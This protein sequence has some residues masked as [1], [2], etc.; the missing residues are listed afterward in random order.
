[1]IPVT[2]G[3]TSRSKK[4]LHKRRH[5]TNNMRHCLSKCVVFSSICI[6]L[7]SPVIA[8]A[9]IPLP[10]FRRN[11]DYVEW[12]Q[13]RVKCGANTSSVNAYS[14]FSQDPNGATLGSIKPSVS[15]DEYLDSLVLRP[16][17]WGPN[18]FPNLSSYLVAIDKYIKVYSSVGGKGYC[19]DFG[20]NIEHVIEVELPYLQVSRIVS[21]SLIAAAWKQAG[22]SIDNSNFVKMMTANLEHANYIQQGLSF[23]EYSTASKIRD[24]T[25]TS[26]LAALEAGFLEK[27]D[28]QLLKE[29][30]NNYDSSTLLEVLA[31]K[32]YF[33]PVGYFDLLQD[34]TRYSVLG[35]K[36]KKK[37]VAYWAT[38]LGYFDSS[39]S[40]S[41]GSRCIG[42]ILSENPRNVAKKIDDYYAEC[43]KLIFNG[44]DP[45]YNTAFATLEK[46]YSDESRFFD[47]FPLMNL[48]KPY[49][50]A[51]R[52]ERKRRL[53]H[54]AINLLDYFYDNAAFT[55]ACDALRTID[56][57]I[58]IDP[59]TQDT[60]E[61]WSRT[62]QL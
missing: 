28:A 19:V 20:D 7:A 10:D 60:F 9:G 22:S 24:I 48:V 4:V 42:E 58:L 14:L 21:R 2:L 5:T 26:I 31:E 35:P 1:M 62:G 32:L 52:L 36:F 16:R 47:I 17:A 57:S 37:R 33:E 43:R 61:K 40:S 13:D 39:A 46:K 41:N 6:F 15:I 18:K 49:E 29:L 23:T 38:L 50:M 8:N 53:T 54:L 45:N 27:T 12:L 56:L 51:F 34:M 3:A 59:I 44:F 30:L 55:E 11:V 25:Y